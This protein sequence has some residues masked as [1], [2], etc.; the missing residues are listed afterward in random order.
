MKKA[1]PLFLFLCLLACSKPEPRQAAKP[2]TLF[3]DR[4]AAFFEEALPLG[5]GR[6]GAMVYGGPHTDSLSLNDITLWTGEPDRGADHFDY[7]HPKKAEKL[8]PWGEAAVWI[9]QLREAL[10]Q[11]DYKRADSLQRYVQGHYSETYQPLGCLKITYPAGRIKDYRRELDLHTATARV[12]YLRDGKA[13]SAEYVVSAPDSALVI[14]LQGEA[15]IEAVIGLTGQLPHHTRTEAETLVSDG[16]AAFHAYPDYYR[17]RRHFLYNSGRGIHYRTVVHCPQAVPEGDSLLRISGVR[18]ALIVVTNQTSFNGYDKDPV[19]EGREYRQS[20]LRQASAAVGQG[21]EQLSARQQADYKAFFDRVSLNLGATPEEIRSLPT[22]RQLR[23]Y[24]NGEVNPELEALY[25]QFGRYLLIASSRTP[26]V[27]ANLQGLWNERMQPPWSSNYTTNINLEENYWAAESAALPEMHQPLL[28]F[29]RNLSVN[30]RLSAQ[31]F[32]GVE[33]GW[34]EAQNTDIWAMTCPVG[35]GVGDPDWANWNMGGAWLSTHLWEHWLFSRNREELQRDYPA[36][37]GAAQFCLGSLVERDGELITSPGTS[38]ENYFLTPQGDTC[39]TSYGCTADLALIRECLSDAREAALLLQDAAFAERIDSILPRLR[40]YQIGQAGNLQEWYHDWKDWDPR[41]RHQSHLIG[42]YPGHQ[43]QAGTPLADAAHKTLE[44]RGFKT[45]GWS[46]G[47]RV[48]LYARLGDGE[49]AYKM[50][51]TLLR[52][53]SPQKY[54]GWGRRR[55]GGTYP[56]LLDAHPPFQIDGNFGGCAGVL[57]ML[58]QS[59]ADSLKLLPALPQAWPSGEL[60]GVRTR[61]G[62]TLDL[63]WENGEVAEWKT[64]D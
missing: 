34:C 28:A 19:R 17:T 48:N 56:N 30:G 32:Y 49:S 61:M 47:W 53:V 29:I 57:E 41:H 4:P 11:E 3:Y 58:V 2:L 20:A 31:N 37:K 62:K 10:D 15:P 50:Y 35:L 12:E 26:G 36:L 42:L 22:D 14:H 63:R 18:E 27:P 24:A 52:F 16:Y 46:S 8:T 9:P 40:P 23:R 59:T 45:T 1:L 51:R 13:F 5:N 6:L 64:Y 54:K 21:W 7:Q 55:G 38:P 25:F 33:E 60:R 43:I 39:A 44:I